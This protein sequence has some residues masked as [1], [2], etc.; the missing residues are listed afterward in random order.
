MPAWEVVSSM[1]F[2][3]RLKKLRKAEKLT[4][5][6]FADRLKISRN[7]I[8]GYET[9][10]TEPSGSAISLICRIF[11][12]SET[13]LRTGEG[14]MYTED[15]EES[16][17]VAFMRDTLSSESKDFR[18]RFISALAELNSDEWSLLEKIVKIFSEKDQE[19][20]RD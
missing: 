9:G 18:K 12:V 16:K 2:K 10:R 15:F 4:Q 13:W 3:D 14:S 6:E 19:K 8:A 1:E 5:Q 17:F 11:S 20:R 7:N